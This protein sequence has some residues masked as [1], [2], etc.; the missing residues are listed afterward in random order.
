MKM[1]KSILLS[2]AASLV[3]MTGAQAADLPVKAKAVEYVKV[4]SAYGAGF[5]YV[6]G[7][8]LCMRVGGWVRMEAAY[9]VN[10]NITQGPLSG[11]RRDR[12]DQNDFV[13]RARGYVTVDTRY[14]SEYGTV[15]TYIAVGYSGNNSTDY[16]FNRGFI[17]VAGFTVGI[18]TSFY[19]FYSVPAVQ[20]FGFAPGSDTGDGGYR[21]WAYTAQFGGGWSATISAEEQRTIGVWNT[22]IAYGNPLTAAI[23]PNNNGVQQ[24]ILGATGIAATTPFQNDRVGTKY[25]DFVANVR[26]DQSWGSIQGMGALHDTSAGYYPGCSAAG[27]A[28]TVAIDTFGESSTITDPAKAAAQ[29][30]ICSTSKA[31]VNGHPG[32]RLGWAAGIGAKLNVPSMGPGDNL[33]GQVSWT[34][35][36]SKYNFQNDSF[37]PYIFRGNGRLGMGFLTDAV[38]AGHTGT[39][40]NGSGAFT[41]SLH[42]TNTFALN[43]AYDHYWS[44]KLRTSLWVGYG[45]VSYDATAN[46][47]I[48]AGMSSGASYSSSTNIISKVG[49]NSIVSSVDNCSNNWSTYSIGSRTQ[50]NLTKQTYLSLEGV[51]THLNSANKGSADILNSGAQNSVNGAVISDVN[52]WSARIRMHSDF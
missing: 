13:N 11:N 7:T 20:L 39:A 44:P 22:N 21:V 36:A 28:T 8:D 41:D 19:D 25:P 31:N 50:W 33:V 34:H 17:Q 2:S 40:P 42:L 32:D 26:L 38:F 27:A 12:T 30:S 15:R 49:N 47:N 3:V 4:C 18:A 24:G 16:S 46:A 23:V 52:I 6:P 10:S 14:N 37:S 48:C 1:V 43:A 5:Y 51:Y 45:Q 29:S 35:G 9:N